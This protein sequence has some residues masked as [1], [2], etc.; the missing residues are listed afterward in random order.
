MKKT[1]G[2]NN[3]N[4]IPDPI[5][6]KEILARGIIKNTQVNSK[7]TQ[8][9]N[10]I[11]VNDIPFKTILRGDPIKIIKEPLP[12]KV[13]NIIYEYNNGKIFTKTDKKDKK[14]KKDKNINDRKKVDHIDDVIHDIANINTKQNIKS[15]PISLGVSFI[16]T[17][18]NDEK[19]INQCIL[20]IV[21]L[22]DEIILVD[23]NSTDKTFEIMCTLEKQFSNVHVYQ[24]NMNINKNSKESTFADFYNWCLTKVTKKYIIKWGANYYAYK[25]HLQ[26]VIEFI[27]LQ[28]DNI[29]MW[30]SGLCILEYNKLYYVKKLN[31]YDEFR[32]FTKQLGFRWYNNESNICQPSMNSMKINIYIVTRPVFFEVKSTFKKEYILESTTTDY[33]YID[34]YIILQE[35]IKNKYDRVIKINIP[36]DSCLGDFCIKFDGGN[37][38]SNIPIDQLIIKDIRYTSQL[39]SPLTSPLT[40][41]LTSPLTSPSTSPL[42]LTKPIFTYKNEKNILL[43]IDS[44]G[45]AFDN[46]SKEIIKYKPKDYNIHVSY[47]PEYYNTYCNKNTNI[48]NINKQLRNGYEYPTISPPNVDFV[49][50]FHYGDTNGEILKLFP[51]N[52]VAL[53]IYDYSTWVNNLDKSAEMKN[54][55]KME[56]FIKNTKYILYACPHIKKHVEQLFNINHKLLYTCFDG[57]DATKFQYNDYSEDILTRNKLVIAWVGNSNPNYHGLTKKFMIIKETV[58]KMK[59]RFIFKPADRMTGYISHDKMPAYY[60]SIDIVVCLSICEGTPNQILEGSSSGRAFISTDVGIVSPL[61]N[62]IDPIG[63]PCGLIIGGTSEDLTSALNK[64]YDNRQMMVD[65]GKNGRNAVEKGWDWQNKTKQFYDLFNGVV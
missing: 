60:A 9:N 14:D 42:T 52:K 5:I 63:K 47:Y 55:K 59:D 11:Q 17:A 54:M 2:D 21:E 58:E 34:D 46:I 40:L 50:F 24:Y 31:Y 35:L 25:N 56:N 43:L 19:T 3:P 41:P 51:I 36:F 8:S 12:V 39:T 44:K 61:N 4:K 13:N 1:L 16:V 29:C 6:I 45:W 48:N 27:K 49:V 32:I 28:N 38:K 65:M 10:N 20:D 62:T 64:L 26:E 23:N 53:C 15:E 33:R 57:V 22:A 37:S 18:N 7:S 30:F